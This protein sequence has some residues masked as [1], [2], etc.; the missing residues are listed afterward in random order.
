MSLDAMKAAIQKIGDDWEIQQTASQTEID[1]TFAKLPNKPSPELRLMYEH[2]NGGYIN[3]LEIFVLFEMEQVNSDKSYFRDF[4]S[5]IFFASDG[6]SGWFFID[7]NDDMGHGEGAIFW[8]DRGSMTWGLTIHCADSLEEFLLIVADGKR[9]WFEKEDL[10]RQSTNDMLALLDK[11]DKKWHANPATSFEEL[12]AAVERIGA[13]LPYPLRLLLKKSNGLIFL[14]TGVVIA[15]V[16]QFKAFGT[17][18]NVQAPPAIIF[19]QEQN[20]QYAITTPMWASLTN[21]EYLSEGFVIRLMAGQTLQQA[22]VLGWLPYVIEEWLLPK[23]H[24]S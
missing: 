11:E 16:S 17:V 9:P 20:S 7:T 12:T 24:T 2:S 10:T 5:A 18:P 15:N 14:E 22:K 8:V 21:V 13:A 23:K 4:P 6:G 3:E 19:A 1:E